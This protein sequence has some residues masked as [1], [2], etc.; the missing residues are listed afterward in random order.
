MNHCIDDLMSS[1]VSLKMFGTM[2]LID[3]AIVSQMFL[4]L[5]RAESRFQVNKSTIAIIESTIMLMIVVIVSLIAQKV[6]LI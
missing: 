3:F 5:F 1:R 2:F 6:S 4:I